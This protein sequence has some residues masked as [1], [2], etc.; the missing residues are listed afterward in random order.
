[1]SLLGV[2]V[3]I[4]YYVEAR[5]N[6][7][8]QNK[9]IYQKFDYEYLEKKFDDLSVYKSDALHWNMKELSNLMEI[10]NRALEAYKKL[11]IELGIKFHDL[12]SAL[13]RVKK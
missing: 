10:G 3:I 6:S 12:N 9:V 1:M 2:Y 8:F 7:K 11:F 13:E 5:K 4:G